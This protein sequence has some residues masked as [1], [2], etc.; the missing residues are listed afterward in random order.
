[1]KR[2]AIFLACLL[3]FFGIEAFAVNG[4]DIK[5]GKPVPAADTRITR[6]KAAGTVTEITD[7]TLKIERTVK[8]KMESMEFVLD[9]PIVKIM[10][11]DKVL[12]SY[13]AKEGKNIATRVAKT[14]IKK[15]TPKTTINAKPA[16]DT[17]NRETRGSYVLR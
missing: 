8:D 16:K 4:A 9:K 2:T 3:L 17:T 5:A 6:M 11:G 13:V 7:V 14:A 15:T 10:V 12:V 1:M